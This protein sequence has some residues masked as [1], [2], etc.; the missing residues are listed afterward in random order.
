MS[1]PKTRPTAASV[2]DFVAAQPDERAKDCRAVIAMMR[3]ATGE[4]PVMWGPG[5]VGFGRYEATRSDG[6]TYEWP[7]I[8]FSPRKNDLTLYVL[9]SESARQEALLKQLGKHKTGK[10]CL[11]VKRLSDVDTGVLQQLI[12]TTVEA[13]EP[14]RLR[15]AKKA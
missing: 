3:K 5:I 12:D 10:A 2:D 13:M 9:M 8:G 7:V 14:S 6:K 4:K 15:A 11:Y 1:E